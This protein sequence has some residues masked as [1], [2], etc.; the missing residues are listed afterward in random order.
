MQHICESLELFAKEVMPE[1][2]AKEPAHQEWKRKVLAGEIELEDIDTTPYRRPLRAEHGAD[3]GA[4]G[5]GVADQ[6]TDR[7]VRA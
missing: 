6:R 3:T 7:A 1:F 2:H 4:A 5:G